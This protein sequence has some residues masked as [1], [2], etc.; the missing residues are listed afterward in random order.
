MDGYGLSRELILATKSAKSSSPKILLLDIET[1]LNLVW[2]FTLFKAYIPPK[3]IETASR[4]L[5]WAAK[6]LDDDEV[7][8][9]NWHHKDF[10]DKIWELLDEADG[11]IHYNGKAFDIK[12]LNREFLLANKPPPSSFMDI[13]LLTTVR[14]NF[15]FPS[16]KLEWVTIEMG[17]EGKVENRGV[18]LWLDCQKHNKRDAWKEM[19]EYNIRDVTEMEPLYYELRPWIK[20]HPN[21]GHWNDEGDLACHKCGSTNLKKDGWERKTLVPYQRYRCL[22]CRSPLKGRTKVTHDE[23]GKA[24]PQPSTRI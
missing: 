9:R 11:C 14:R 5:C 10:V 8:F 3:Q 13:D 24:L 22:D 17:Y 7:I 19:K 12:N 20:N 6:W 21:F 1:S 15:K 23:N 2:T 4:V 18:Q 16:N